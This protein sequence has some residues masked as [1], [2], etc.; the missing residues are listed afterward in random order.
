MEFFYIYFYLWQ[1]EENETFYENQVDVSIEDKFELPGFMQPDQ[2]MDSK[3]RKRDHPDYDAS[4]LH[5]PEK[6]LKNE[7]PMF[8]QYWE[9]KTKNYDKICLFRM[10]RNFMAFYNDAFVLHRC[11]SKKLFQ[12]QQF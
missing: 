10:G 9:T 2:I 7:S 5:I 3:K 6:I 8:L 11:L 4:T 12:L 1:D